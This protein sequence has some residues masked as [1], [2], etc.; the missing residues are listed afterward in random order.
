MKKHLR[1]AQ[2]QRRRAEVEEQKAELH[3][4][5][6]Y[7][8]NN[9]IE[10]AGDHTNPTSCI[11]SDDEC[12]TDTSTVVGPAYAGHGSED[13]AVSSDEIFSS[14]KEP[15]DNLLL[16]NTL[17]RLPS[18]DATLWTVD[19]FTQ[20]YCIDVGP[21]FCRNRDGKYAMSSRQHKGRTRN[22]VIQPSI[23]CP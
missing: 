7:F 1:G 18:S 14:K 2:K 23:K 16:Q 20:Q 10:T 4:I 11:S 8:I 6:S 3:C 13:Q 21:D 22:S 19:A 15:S 9:S 5:S 17:V 12:V